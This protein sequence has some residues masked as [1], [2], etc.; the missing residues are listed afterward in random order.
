MTAAA[1]NNPNTA[2][3]NQDDDFPPQSITSYYQDDLAD[4]RPPALF[5]KGYREL[6]PYQH[7]S[8]GGVTLKKTKN[9]RR[10]KSGV[11]LE[12]PISPKRASW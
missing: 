3:A 9:G 2:S 5:K 8:F 12:C 11:A 7:S 6:S 1:F 10:A 4:L